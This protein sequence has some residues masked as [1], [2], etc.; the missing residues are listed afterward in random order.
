LFN[1]V[2]FVIPFASIFKIEYNT[3]YTLI[4]Y[5]KK[6]KNMIKAGIVGISG[7]GGIELYRLLVNHPEVSIVA[8]SSR[9][10]DGKDLADVFPHTF[11]NSL[12][13][14]NYS[15]EELAE[16]C[17]V[18]FTSVPHGGPAMAYAIPIKKAG[19]KFI[20]LSADFRLHDKDIYSEWY[21]TEHTCPELLDEAVYGLA[22]LHREEIKKAWLIANPG[23]YTTNGI[24]AAAP[25]L[26]GR[27]ID[28]GSIII[29]AKSGVSGA[30]RKTKQ[31][32]HFSE[33]DEGFQAYGI[34]SHRHTPE[35]EQELSMIAGQNLTLTFT[36]NLVP[37][38]RGILSV[39]Y[40]D[41]TTSA[42]L[43]DLY[44]MYKEFYKDSP[45]V[46]LRRDILPNTKYVAGSNYIDLALRIDER[47]N[48]I[49]VIAALDNLVKGAAGSA[50]QCMNLLYN[51]PETTGLPLVS[52]Y[53]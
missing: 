24:L 16:M 49:I 23:C 4:K 15:P 40:A 30:G 48:R 39:V 36:P 45:F 6:G 28:P 11:H 10:Y 5:N 29:D 21:K 46:R 27:V 7:Y 33:L 53:P 18:L 51:L 25:L 17:D 13:C 43:D 34:A 47:T 50:V 19:K 52:L 38:I 26:A 44:T 31:M 32:F 42:S 14:K 3:S 41:R 9:T 37:M 35:I 1:K 20:D 2:I 12:V 8:V 22:E